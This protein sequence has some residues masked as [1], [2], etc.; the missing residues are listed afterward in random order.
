MK[1]AQNT[2]TV[3]TLKK[4]EVL[5][6]S[7]RKI[8]GGKIS[9]EFAEIIQPEDRAPSLVSL[10]NS[11]D[12]RFNIATAPRRAW[13]SV[14][15]KEALEYLGID[16]A[17]LTSEP[18]AYNILNPSIGQY[19]IK[20]QVVDR[21]EEE[22]IQDMNSSTSESRKASISFKMN[23]AKKNAKQTK[24]GKFFFMNGGLIYSDVVAVLGKPNHRIISIK[25]GNPKTSGLFPF[26]TTFE[27]ESKTIDLEV[28]KE[29]VFA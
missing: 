21:T 14:E 27:K 28:Q 26:G 6:V 18:K 3:E 24:N 9:L 10:M 5:L 29:S 25:D 11:S 15:P 19:P 12:E 2:P 7:V 8:S 1:T 23:N 22:M 20:L 17:D 16:E 4:G 13:L